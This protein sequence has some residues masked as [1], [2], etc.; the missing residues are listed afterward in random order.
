MNVNKW[1]YLLVGSVLSVVAG[2]SQHAAE[3]EQS[4]NSLYQNDAS[5][6]LSSTLYQCESAEFV[7][8]AL[9]DEQ[10]LVLIDGTENHLH[11]VPSASGVKYTLDGQLENDAE[12]ALFTKGK[13]AILT[14][15]GQT[16][17]GCMTK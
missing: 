10:V 12:V 1:Q 2:C 16:Y 4:A 7:V 17:N 9:D 13:Q 3:T 15:S 6:E 11:R 5:R 8:T 14:I